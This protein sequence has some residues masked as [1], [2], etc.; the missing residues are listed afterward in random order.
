MLAACRRHRVQFMDG[1]MFRHS[2]RGRMQVALDDG[3]SVGRLRR[4]EHKDD[5]ATAALCPQ[6]KKRSAEKLYYPGRDRDQ[7]ENIAALPGYAAIKR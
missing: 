7:I 5:P 2:A 6:L 3:T 1:V 4:V